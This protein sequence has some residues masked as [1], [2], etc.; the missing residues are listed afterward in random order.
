LKSKFGKCEKLKLME[1]D[2]GVISASDLEEKR[3]I[4]VAKAL[5]YTP[6]RDTKV[7]RYEIFHKVC[8]SQIHQRILDNYD[9][10][11]KMVMVYKANC[12]LV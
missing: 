6:F 3:R 7:S 12:T 1:T 4:S 2:V 11:C 10:R 5:E 8:K 9:R